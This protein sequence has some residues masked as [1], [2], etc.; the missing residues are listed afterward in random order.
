MTEIILKIRKRI[1]TQWI[2]LSNKIISNM[3]FFY[4]Y[5]LFLL[6]TKTNIERKDLMNLSRL[7]ILNRTEKPELRQGM[8]ADYE[9]LKLDLKYI[10]DKITIKN[11]YK[12]KLLYSLLISNGLYS[13]GLLVKKKIIEF[14]NNNQNYKMQKKLIY[15][16]VLISIEGLESEY[17]KINQHYNIQ[18]IP[19]Y[20]LALINFTN[21]DGL[22]NID[23][24]YSEYLKNKTV[25][26]VGPAPSN[27]RSG[28]EID[29]FNIVV[30]P[31]FNMEFVKKNR[32]YIG[33]KT[34]VSYYQLNSKSK[35]PYESLKKL[36]FIVNS[37]RLR[38]EEISEMKNFRSRTYSFNFE[39]LWGGYTTQ[40]PKILIDIIINKQDTENIKLF[41][42]NFYME[43]TLYIPEYRGNP[44]TESSQ[45]NRNDLY[46]LWNL[47][48]WHDV[49]SNWKVVKFIVKSYSI[50]STEKI[51]LLLS[52][53]DDEFIE[54]M[55]ELYGFKR[56]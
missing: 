16:Y 51:E 45:Y 52:Y 17:L 32:T 31:K 38:D 25:A 49:L 30:R 56:K 12:Y 46:Y 13:L 36:E 19:D 3:P 43:P 55:E 28:G 53:N 1:Q 21:K 48:S 22:N 5:F 44:R 40:L 39:K 10:A 11:Y 15:E 33:S 27:L 34:D 26:I 6:F 18:S 50:S 41:N 7:S 24:Y 35:I 14:L 29:G 4:P 2:M 47:H 23:R 9:R 54:V 42:F 37:S 8:L 20:F